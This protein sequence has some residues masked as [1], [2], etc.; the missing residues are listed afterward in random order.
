METLT[1]CCEAMA[2]YMDDFN[3]GWVLCCKECYN[4]V[5]GE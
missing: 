2:T 4:E 1:E 5:G 3:D